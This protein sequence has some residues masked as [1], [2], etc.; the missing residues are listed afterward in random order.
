MLERIKRHWVWPHLVPLFVICLLI[1]LV[2]P[3]YGIVWAVRYLSGLVGGWTLFGIFS[4]LA[5]YLII[6]ANVRRGQQSHL[7]ENYEGSS[8]IDTPARN[9]MEPRRM[10]EMPYPNGS[11]NGHVGD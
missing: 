11:E 3:G 7:R 1:D 2:A 4:V 6:W 8:V 9:G 5:L 10:R